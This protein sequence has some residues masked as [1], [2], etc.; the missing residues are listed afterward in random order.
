MGNYGK[1]WE[2]VREVRDLYISLHML[3][4]VGFKWDLY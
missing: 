4:Y 3:E 2:D 1:L